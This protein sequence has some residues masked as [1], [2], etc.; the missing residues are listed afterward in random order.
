M[1]KGKALSPW[2]F[3]SALEYAIRKFQANRGSLKLNGIHQLQVYADNVR[4][5]RGSIHTI[6]NTEALVVASK[7]TDLQ[8]NVK[9]AKY[10]G[11]DLTSACTAKPQDKDK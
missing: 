5:L 7:D 10:V 6:K 9:K 4:I 11:H 2:F 3:N 1:K 8:V